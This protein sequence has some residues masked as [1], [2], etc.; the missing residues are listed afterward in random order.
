[1]PDPEDS[2]SITGWQ[3][4]SRLYRTRPGLGWLAALLA[5]PLL[6]GL[7]GWGMLDRSEGIDAAIPEIDPTVS[8]PTVEAPDL[9]L[10]PL[11]GLLSIVRIGN[12]FT[13]SGDL[14]DLSL[15]TDL[16]DRLRGV[17]GPN[18]NVI[19]ALNINADAAAPNLD[20]IDGVWRKAIDIPDLNWDLR[21]G[22]LTLTGTAPNAQIKSAVQA[23]AENAW[24]N[25]RIDNQIQ[26]FT[27]QQPGGA[28]PPA[29]AT[30]AAPSPA[31]APADACADL[32][33]DI[34][35]LLN[36]PVTFDTDGYTL[37]G[38]T[39]QM[40]TRVAEKITACPGSRINVD[41]YTDSSGNDAINVPL[42]ANRAKAVADF[43]VTQGVAGDSVASQ[44]HGS[45]SP[46]ADNDTDEGKAQ[47]R[48]VEITVS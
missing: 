27:G 23:A 11:P 4:V 41:G 8:M 39:E 24:P 32:Q 25:S 29:E 2:R 3:T 46:V 17:F 9:N 19:D 43:L 28:T 40:L 30:P 16:L 37:T 47:N 45:A 13:L 14:P 26:V 44:G 48:R 5:I 21:D 6:L 1:M 33:A 35:A 42:S 22:T 36:Q 12:D 38:S 10:A 20:G 31:P 34:T 18:I 7:L 15:K